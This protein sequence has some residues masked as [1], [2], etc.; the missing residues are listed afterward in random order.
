[1]EAAR[2]SFGRK[3]NY[4]EEWSVP[5]KLSGALSLKALEIRVSL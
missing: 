1:M 5:V 3:G 4:L 2:D